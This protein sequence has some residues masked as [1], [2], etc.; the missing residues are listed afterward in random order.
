MVG[1]HYGAPSEE[2][3]ATILKE[4]EIDWPQFHVTDDALD[5]LNVTGFPYG[6]LV[7]PQ[8]RIEAFHV[9][10]DQVLTALEKNPKP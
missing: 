7:D 5:Q 8:G 6:I 1:L 10:L 9:D 4:H 3:L 2:A